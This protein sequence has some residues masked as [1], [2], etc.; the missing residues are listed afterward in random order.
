MRFLYSLIV[1]AATAQLVLG[2]D[3]GEEGGYGESYEE[4]KRCDAPNTQAP[5]N[6][7]AISLDQKTD[8]ANF[9]VVAKWGPGYKASS[10][11]KVGWGPGKVVQVN[12]YKFTLPYWGKAK[13]DNWI[14]GG[15]K[16]KVTSVPGATRLGFLLSSDMGN[17][18]G[19]F[20]VVY[21]DCTTQVE[22]VGSSDW[23]WKIELAP[24][25]KIAINGLA[26]TN[27]GDVR[28]YI[29]EVDLD[30]SKEIAYVE[31]PTA[32]EVYDVHPYQ[33]GIK[34]HI[35]VFALST[36]KVGY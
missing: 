8:P 36:K 6:N 30:P 12:G 31:F 7:K 28:I 18:G 4:E 25:N 17:F 1:L 21:T 24:G 20:K 13:K 33:K 35:H 11:L 3:Y 14:E 15:Q 29:A 2:G 10:L 34:G 9:D 5:F 22:R 27:G 19:K 16:V 26:A 23:K 32:K